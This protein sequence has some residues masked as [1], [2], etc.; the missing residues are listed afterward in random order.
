MIVWSDLCK[1]LYHTM[2][3]QC[4]FEIAAICLLVMHHFYSEIKLVENIKN[5]IHVHFWKIKSQRKPRLSRN[6]FIHLILM[7][8]IWISR[9]SRLLREINMGI[10]VIRTQINIQKSG[11][12]ADNKDLS[13]WFFFINLMLSLSSKNLVVF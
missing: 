6:V 10:E 12:R 5:A 2:K 3:L 13:Y 11:I 1:T 7:L 9:K 4:I 8:F